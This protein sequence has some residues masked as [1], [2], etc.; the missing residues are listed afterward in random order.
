MKIEKGKIPEETV[1]EYFIRSI[2]SGNCKYFSYIEL[3][4]TDEKI[5]IEWLHDCET[6]NQEYFFIYIDS[7][8]EY[9]IL[10]GCSSFKIVQLYDSKVHNIDLSAKSDEEIKETV[11]TWV[12][13]CSGY[14][15]SGSVQHITDEILKRRNNITE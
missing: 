10:V 4:K 12:K 2:V 14:F 3:H 11:L 8:E 7:E 15:V 13:F 5:Y 9:T 1:A 6:V